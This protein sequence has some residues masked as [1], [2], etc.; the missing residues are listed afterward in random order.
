MPPFRQL[1]HAAK[2]PTAAFRRRRVAHLPHPPLIVDQLHLL[3][4]E[5]EVGIWITIFP[6]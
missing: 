5:E 6:K 3:H 4:G 2:R 1:G